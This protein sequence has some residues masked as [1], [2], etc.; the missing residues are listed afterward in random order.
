MLGS[1]CSF[2]LGEDKPGELILKTFNS[3]I[4]M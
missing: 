4:N 1:D 2:P 3:G